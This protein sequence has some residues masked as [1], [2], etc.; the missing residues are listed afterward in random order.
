MKCLIDDF[1]LSFICSIV[2][3]VESSLW[4]FFLIEN[5]A[6]V[7]F[8]ASVFSIFYLLTDSSAIFSVYEMVQTLM[9]HSFGL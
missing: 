3:A 6:Y 5:T 1:M 7:L 4:E 9:Q 8:F 2:I